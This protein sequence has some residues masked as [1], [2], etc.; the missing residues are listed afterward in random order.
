MYNHCPNTTHTTAIPKI[1][2]QI[3]LITSECIIN[4][5]WDTKAI[6]YKHF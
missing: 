4:I 1:I 5:K 2:T 6:V 3:T